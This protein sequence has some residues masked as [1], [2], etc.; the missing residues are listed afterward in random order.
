[1]TAVAEA[2]FNTTASTITITCIK[3][4]KMRRFLAFIL[5]MIFGIVFVLGAIAGIIYVAVAVIHPKQVMPESE[6]YLGDFADM[7]VVDMA[8]S[9]QQLYLSKIGV[10]DENGNYFSLGEFLS[11]YNIDCKEAFGIDLPQDVLDI[12][13]F[14]FFD[15][16]G[17][18]KAMKQIK[19]SSIPSIINMFGGTN[20]DGTP[21]NIISPEAV[22]ELANY[23]LYDLL[24]DESKG[25]AYVFQNIKFA[26]IIQNLFPAEDSDNKLMWAVGQ[27]SIGKLI[28]GISG[29]NNILMQLKPNGAFEALGALSILDIVGDGGQYVSAIFGDTLTAD[30]I[31]ENGELNLD[32]VINGVSIG[33]MLGCQRNE[34]TELESYVKLI[35][36]NAVSEDPDI[37]VMY[38]QT[39]DGR[40]YVKAF[41]GKYYE[42][43]IT[44]KTV[45][46]THTDKCQ[47]NGQSCVKKEYVHNA[48]CYG[49][50]WY[51]TTLCETKNHDHSG[52]LKKDDGYYPRTDGLH[53]V[54][55]NTTMADLTSGNNDA[56]IDRIKVLKIA[57]LLGSNKITGVMSNFTDMTINELMNGAIDELFLGSFFG[58]ERI[59]AD[60]KDYIVA[61]TI[62]LYYKENVIEEYP[63]YYARTNANGD[64][65]LSVDQETWYKGEFVCDNDKHDDDSHIAS[66]YSFEWYAKCDIAHDEA[67]DDDITI[68]DGFYKKS[69]GI[70][71]KLASKQVRNL[72]DL[73]GEIKKLTLYDV[74][75]DDSPNVLKE[76]I[77]TPVGEL[78]DA[79]NN[80]YIGGLLQYDREELISVIVDDNTMSLADGGN[81]VYYA[82]TNAV[83]YLVKDG[84]ADGYALQ[85]DDTTYAMSEDCKTWYKAQLVCKDET[86][87]RQH[88]LRKCYAYMWYDGEGD[89]RHVVGGMMAKLA[90]KRVDEMG[91]LN[92]TIK[93]FTIRDVLGDDIP[94]MLLPLADCELGE[95]KNE[96]DNLYIGDVLK[97]KRREI[98][99]IDD[100][101]FLLSGA[102]TQEVIVVKVNG[103]KYAMTN[104]QKVWYEAELK[105]HSGEED[106]KHT[107][108]CFNYVWYEKCEEEDHN[109][110]DETVYFDQV[111]YHKLTGLTRHIVT[112]KV[113]E[114]NS[115]TLFNAINDMT[116]GEI[117]KMDEDTNKILFEMQ[118]VKVGELGK[119][120]NNVYLGS[121]MNY[122]RKR[123]SDVGY[124]T[125]EGLIDNA[126]ATSFVKY[127]IADDKTLYVKSDDNA[128]WYEADL[129]CQLTDTTHIHTVNCYEYVWYVR[130]EN[131][132]HTSDLCPN[133]TIIDGLHYNPVTGLVKA[134][135]NSRLKNV[136]NTINHL[137]IRKLGIDISN[138]NLLQSIQDVELNDL[139]KAVNDVK[140]GVVMGYEK[141]EYICDTNHAHS[142][143]CDCQWLNDGEVVKGLNG[144]ISN[145]TVGQLAG[146]TAITTIAQELTMRDM[147]DTGMLTL[148][149]AQENKLDRIFDTN[150]TDWRDIL[151][152]DFVGQLLDA[153][154]NY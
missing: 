141:G 75:G 25:I 74:L 80:M 82:K 108:D 126:N 29:E 148:T 54:L 84:K 144:K 28:S 1:M 59:A 85:L 33:E 22:A 58:F 3:E 114:L 150:G 102:T 31:S 112:I 120:I 123:M 19:V 48:D 131:S 49:Y 125:V 79:I 64:I 65:A 56:L 70:Q 53:S 145:K 87:T 147:M 76:I 7:S 96:I 93:T 132:K 127:K 86:H 140:M 72:K 77:H 51:T 128:K 139:G 154:P 10:T 68:G 153:I 116:L 106:H 39:E 11:N 42:A 4:D 88:M 118:D 149:T 90:E 142:D 43:E 47:N 100:Y 146:G 97:N 98:D 107:I 110:C 115:R 17:L 91:K 38:R 151:L 16:D 5:G 34:I 89:E 130:C 41:N 2:A 12:P 111:V 129:T 121:A 23:S 30:L 13:A 6:K 27:S 138:N 83:M 94:E 32:S 69:T 14:E 95:M 36:D 63:V 15:D 78:N 117:I 136:S 133:D 113:G 52:E 103:D 109:D 92:E 66:C 104:D 99:D 81:N 134:F 20:E 119:E 71:D 67:C 101:E 122:V 124:A 9:V 24:Q 61:T 46:H 57:D 35:E 45:E 8:K 18:N 105:Y 37:I 135:V 55:A 26:D 73:N 44:C 62:P 143:D 60:A 137:T 152:T 40:V 21:N 50:V